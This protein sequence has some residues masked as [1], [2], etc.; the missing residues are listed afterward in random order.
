VIAMHLLAEIEQ[1]PEKLARITGRTKFFYV[2][3]AALQ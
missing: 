2:R 3:A 1:R